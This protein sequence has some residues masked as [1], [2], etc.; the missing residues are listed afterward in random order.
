L[1]AVFRSSVFFNFGRFSQNPLLNNLL[2]NTG[3]GTPREGLTVGPVIDVPGEGGPGLI[4][5]PNLKIEQA[6]VYEVGYNAEFSRDFALGVT[7]FNKNQTGLTGIRTGGQRRGRLGFEQVFDPGTTYGSSNTPSYRILV[8]QDY[9]TVRG[10]EMQLQRRVRD[11]WGFNVNYSYSRAR[12]NASEP[13][14]EIERQASQG[15]PNNLF[16]V[17]SDI[18]QAHVFNAAVTGQVGQAVPKFRYAS[19]LR[20]TTATVTV[21]A[22]SGFPYTPVLDYY[23][24]GAAK[25]QRN[26]GRAQGTSS[27]DMLLSKGITVANVRYDL[28]VQARNILDRKNCVTVFPTTGTCEAGAV[29]QSRARQGNTV[30]PDAATSTYTNRADFFGERRTIYGGVNVS[31]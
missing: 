29:D 22:A 7:M 4:G 10:V 1:A 16:E 28:F 27:I 31:F 8:N 17:P 5:N 30:F 18:D 25:V 9:Q 21:H 2:T 11:F 24:F 19:L 14:R 26:S 3:I 15:D 20:N 13:E 23:G 6:T 12:T